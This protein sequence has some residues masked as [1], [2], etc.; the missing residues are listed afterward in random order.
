[1]LIKVGRENAFAIA[2]GVQYDYSLSEK[3]V[4]AAGMSLPSLDIT[5][6]DVELKYMPSLSAAECDE[7]TQEFSRLLKIITELAAMRT[8]VWVLARELKRTQRRV[9]ALE[10]MVIPQAKETKAFIESAI[11]E[12]E[13]DSFFSSKLLKK[14]AQ[15]AENIRRRV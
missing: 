10:K 2:E 13:R 8:T 9:N 5:L 12:K 7:V 6:P 1:M 11:E 14:R 15:N 3:R 4:M